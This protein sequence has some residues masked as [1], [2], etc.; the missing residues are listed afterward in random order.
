[1]GGSGSGGWCHVLE[2]MTWAALVGCCVLLCLC[3]R[4]MASGNRGSMWGFQASNSSLPSQQLSWVISLDK[5]MGF[6]VKKKSDRMEPCHMFTFWQVLLL[7]FEKHNYDTDTHNTHAHKPSP[8]KQAYLE[9][10]APCSWRH[11][12]PLKEQ[13]R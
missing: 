3:W 5:V 8:M 11:A 13:C 4:L 6:S 10:N 7:L 2:G 9:I 12:I 1:M